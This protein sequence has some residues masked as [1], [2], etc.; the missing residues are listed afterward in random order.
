MSKFASGGNEI[1]NMK[2]MGGQHLVLGRG[3][4]GIVCY[5]IEMATNGHNSAKNHIV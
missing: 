1:H 4:G 2:R 5:A 3:L